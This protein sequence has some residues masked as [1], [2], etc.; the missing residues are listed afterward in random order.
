MRRKKEGE[1]GGNHNNSIMQETTV[2]AVTQNMLCNV[3]KSIHDRAHKKHALE[4]N[5]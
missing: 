1:G 2:L 5:I 3:R 4:L